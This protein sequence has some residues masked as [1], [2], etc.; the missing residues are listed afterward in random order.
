MSADR[1]K[2]SVRFSFSLRSG[3]G[4]SRKDMKMKRK[5]NLT[6]TGFNTVR[7]SDV[8]QMNLYLF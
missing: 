3:S 2:H 5:W 1:K 4:H 7:M 8:K 6:D